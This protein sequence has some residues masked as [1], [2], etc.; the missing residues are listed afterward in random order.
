VERA[1]SFIKLSPLM[2]YIAVHE[3]IHVL[4]FN[5]GEIDFN[6]DSEEKEK[7]EAIVDTLT[8]ATLQPVKGHDLEIVLDCFS[9]QF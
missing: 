5:A 7:E 3:L 1:N 8:R 2:L 9:S 4:R 6:A